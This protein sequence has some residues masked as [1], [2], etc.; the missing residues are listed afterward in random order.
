MTLHTI[1][2]HAGAITARGFALL[3]GVGLIGAMTHANIIK[4]GGYDSPMAPMLIFLAAGLG[5]G[6][7]I[8]GRCRGRKALTALVIAG[9]I[10]GEGFAL[11]NT[12]ERTL[13]ARDA[14]Q[15]P[16]R[17]AAKARE[18]TV[19]RIARLETAAAALTTTERLQAAIR[20]KAATEH[21]AI[22]ASTAKDCGR[23][24]K[25]R[26]EK[27]TAAAAADV[28]SAQAD[29]ADRQRKARADLELA[30]AALAAMPVAASDSPLADRLQI[31]AWWIDLAAAVFASL[32]GNGL[33]AALLAFACHAAAA[34]SARGVQISAPANDLLQP[35]PGTPV[36][37]GADPVVD[38]VRAYR[39]RHNRD[40][41]IKEVQAAHGLSRTTA[42]RRIIKAA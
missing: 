8:V 18:D 42:W 5:I 39:A 6:A 1:T 40:P 7:A 37:A 11:L 25:D 19:A 35:G 23:I 4:V 41:Q 29:L 38:W 27:S 9:L 17:A 2:A 28:E 21:A 22:T 14:K 30:R 24:C 3:G 16:I 34:P 13:E 26:L 10:C 32:G 31:P 36:A 33:G 20:T 15:E 12:S